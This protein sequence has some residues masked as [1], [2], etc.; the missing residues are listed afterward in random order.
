MSKRWDLVVS[1][2]D[3]NDKTRYT[4]VGVVFENK[5]KGSLSIVIDKGVSLSSV[6]GAYIN[7]YE[8]KARDERGNQG[9]NDQ[10]TPF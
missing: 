7:G 1:S 3:K 4:K 2:K 9:S 8:P 6:E 5:D 10:D